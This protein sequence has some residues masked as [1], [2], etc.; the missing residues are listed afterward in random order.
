MKYHFKI[1]GLAVAAL[2]LLTAVSAVAQ[3]KAPG[4]APQN[5]QQNL[6]GQKLDQSDRLMVKAAR[7]CQAAAAIL[8]SA[9][10]IYH[11]HRVAAIKA[12]HFAVREIHAGLRGDRSGMANMDLGANNEEGGRFTEEQIQRSNAR[13]EKA[14]DILVHAKNDLMAAAKD[15]NGHKAN[16]IGLIDKALA[17]IRLGLDSVK[18]HP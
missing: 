11:G 18:R 15:Y 4:K 13:M 8:R 12:A 14:A 17:E 10:P 6:L 16:A 1:K 9:L 3:A 7:E 2:I 5:R